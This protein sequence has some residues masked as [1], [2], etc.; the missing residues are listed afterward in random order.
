MNDKKDVFDRIMSLPGLRLFYEPYTKYKAVLLYVFFGGCTTI[1]SIG[2]FILF[3]IILGELLSNVV[4]WV[5]AVTFA[6]I[7]NRIWVFCSKAKGKVVFKEMLSFYSGRLITLILEEVLLFVFVILL[8]LNAV[9]IK[10]I[11][12]FVVLVSN[13]FI[14]KL[15][16]FK[17]GIVK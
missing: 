3:N 14:S 1:V 5:L 4:S 2:S 16:T 8:Q 11:A 9:V 12:Q 6:Y 13:Y 7:T 15:I 10:I 17:E